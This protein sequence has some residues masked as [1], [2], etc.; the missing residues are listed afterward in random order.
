MRFE[1][2]FERYHDEIYR[3]LWRLMG[4]LNGTD[5]AVDAEDLVQEVFIRAYQAFTRLELDSNYRAW[6]YKIAT[7]CAY[8]ALQRGQRRQQHEWLPPLEKPASQD[9]GYTSRIQMAESPQDYA[10]L[11]EAVVAVKQ[12]IVH[13]PAKQ[14]AALVMRYLQELEYNEIAEALDCSEESARANVYQGTKRLR[15]ELGSQ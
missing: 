8:T 4:G 10:M 13:L 5:S 9:G 7:N 2:L 12:A 11:N 15:Q 1:S 14:Q 3:Y 6:L